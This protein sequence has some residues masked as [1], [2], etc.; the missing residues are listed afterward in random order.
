MRRKKANVISTIVLII[1]LLVGLSVMLY[2]II[3]NW[4]N[5]KVQ[6]RAIANYNR[7]VAELDDNET[8]R[9]IAE[10]RD[11]NNQLAQL[12]APFSQ[13]NKISGYE[14]ILDISDSGIMGYIS[15]PAIKAEFP[16]YHG[17][18]EEV[19]NIAAVLFS[20]AFSSFSQIFFTAYFEFSPEAV[21]VD[22]FG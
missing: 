12:Q 6:T 11:Y 17:T 2:P 21:F 18:D 1:I 5:S 9:I 20:R 16:I 4:W 14:N 3:S 15:I 22:N 8:E 19:L 7:V 13:Y 10:A